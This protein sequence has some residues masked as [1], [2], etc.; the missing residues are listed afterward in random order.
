MTL[1]STAKETSVRPAECI[2]EIIPSSVMCMTG[3]SSTASAE[4]R[5]DACTQEDK[6]A[7]E[8]ERV[9]AVEQPAVPRR[10]RLESFAPYARLSIDSLRSP[11]G[12][13]TPAPAPTTTL[14]HQGS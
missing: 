9:D 12:P 11:S 5:E 1:M 13:R 3:I 7:G 6:R 14:P 8:K 2:Q 10:R 4:V